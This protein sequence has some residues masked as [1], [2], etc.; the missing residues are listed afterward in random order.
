MKRTCFLATASLASCELY[1]PSQNDYSIGGGWWN[2]QGWTIKG[3][4]GVHGKQTFNLLGGYIEFD[5]DTTNAKGGVNNN[6]YLVSPDPSYFRA[7][8]DCDIQGQGKPSCMEMDIIENNGNCLAQT[9][10]HTWPN[11]NGDCDRVGCEGQHYRNGWT[12]VKAAFSWDGWMTVTM[13]GTKVDVTHPVPSENAHAYVKETM[14]KVGA[15]I[16]SSQWVGWVP[17]GNCPGGG[18]VA[19]STFQIRNVRVSGTIVQGPQATKCSGSAN[20]TVVV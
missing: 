13:D 14:A 6:L 19:D 4:G 18:D 16:Q 8:D 15:Q 10:W 17:A 1:C 2:G 5:I 3:Y 7:A 11:F 9:T 20:V 12:H